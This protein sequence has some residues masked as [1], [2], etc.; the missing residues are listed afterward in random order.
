MNHSPAVRQRHVFFLS[1]FDPKGASY[2][3]GL[4]VREAAIQALVTGT[5]YEIGPRTRAPGGNSVWEVRH[6]TEIGTTATTF[7]YV[8]WDDIVRANWAR[9]GWRVFAGSL[10]GYSAALASWSALRKVWHASPR[11][12]VALAMPAAFWISALILSLAMGVAVGQ[13]LSWRL[14]PVFGWIIGAG[15]SLGIAWAFLKLEEK[16]GTSWLLRIYEFAGAWSQGRVAGLEQRLDGLAGALRTRLEDPAI[17]EVLLVGFSVGSLLAVSATARLQQSARRRK[18]DLSRLA[19][20]TLGN[21]IPLLGLMKGAGAFR[22]ELALLGQDPHVAW[23]DF[24]SVT[25]WGSFAL[26]DP[27]A[28]CLDDT[29][30]A[31]RIYRPQVASPRFHLMFEPEQYSRIVKN[32]RRIHMQYLMAGQR[33]TLYD[34][35]AFTAGS[36]RL[37]DRL[38]GSVA[39]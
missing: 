18:L 16:L 33:P 5:A 20:V 39:P 31:G 24:S 22:A 29:A 1:G 28:L 3:H 35:F 11:T 27:I 10:R 2:Y 34:Y 17:D 14:Q 15:A 6:E 13:G 9:H 19:L 36:Q 25:D 23:V 30:Q 21:C 7:E 26:V 38:H 8:R 37:R 32:K 4:Y 12:L